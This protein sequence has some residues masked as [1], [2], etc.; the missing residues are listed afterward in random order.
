[1][2]KKPSGLRER[3]KQ[4]NC[5]V[6]CE[7]RPIAVAAILGAV[8]TLLAV[9]GAVLAVYV[10]HRCLKKSRS[11]KDSSSSVNDQYILKNFAQIT[12]TRAARGCLV[13]WSPKV[14]VPGAEL[15]HQQVHTRGASREGRV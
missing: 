11:S 1:M 4:D 5:L 2:V 13:A 10:T 9:G 6:G 7:T 12:G 14:H 15:R 3:G 8:C